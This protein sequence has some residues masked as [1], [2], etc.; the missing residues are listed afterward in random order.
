MATTPE[1][2]TL[3]AWSDQPQLEISLGED[4]FNSY[5]TTLYF[6]ELP[7]TQN[8]VGVGSTV[9]VPVSLLYWEAVDSG[10][11]IYN[12]TIYDLYL[13]GSWAEFEYQPWPEFQ[14]LAVS[15]LAVLL[16]TDDT[17]QSIPTVQLW[18]WGQ[19]DW[20]TIV[21]ANWGKFAIEDYEPFI[22]P[23]NRVR[24]RLEDTSQYGTSIREVYP[25][26][27]GNMQ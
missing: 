23:G 26:L 17:F 21:R 9:E 24:I 13:S 19:E 14:A 5:A 22:G 8:L 4:P 12:P 2:V 16:E 11:G 20:V 15:E 10:G 27:T 7:L 18:D 3:I 1:T 6:L 25:I